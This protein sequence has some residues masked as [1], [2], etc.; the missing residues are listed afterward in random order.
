[1]RRAQSRSSAA[2]CCVQLDYPPH[3]HHDKFHS[4]FL[5]IVI[6][7]S[8]P[9]FP[10][11]CFVFSSPV[12]CFVSCLT[13]STLCLLSVPRQFSPIFFHHLSHV[14][15]SFIPVSSS[16]LCFYCIF[17][18]LQ[19]L[20]SASLVFPYLLS[21]Y[22]KL[23]L[24]L[25]LL[26]WSCLYGK[27][28]VF[29]QGRSFQ[30]MRISHSPVTVT[31]RASLSSSLSSPPTWSTLPSVLQFVSSYSSLFQWFLAHEVRKSSSP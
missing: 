11:L 28:P 8:L 20:L 3:T 2:V 12:P 13:V 30:F 17:C 25:P 24:L 14:R 26:A 9:L 1:M 27:R 10:S 5:Y 4:F 18:Y 19:Y 7:F 16:Y 15:V 29:E 6:Y 21:L 31:H 22:L 23:H